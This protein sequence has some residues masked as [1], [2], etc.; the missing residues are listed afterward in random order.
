MENQNISNSI[1]NR[2]SIANE[3]KQTL[4]S[5]ETN[6]KN[7][8][9]KRGIYIYGSPGCGKTH[10]VTTLLKE[11]NYDIIKYDAG[12]VRNKALIDTITSNNISNRN[13]L[14]MM[15]KKVKKIA[16]VMDEI[17]GMNNGDKGGIT[18]LIKIIRQKKTKKQQLESITTN[19]IICIGNY[20]IDKKIKE[21][22]KVCNTY[23]LKSPNQQQMKTILKLSIPTI[24][25]EKG[26]SYESMILNYIQGDMRKLMFVKDIFN[27]NSKNDLLTDTKIKTIFCNKSYNED[28]KKITQSLLNQPTKLSQHNRFM[29]ETDRTIVALLWHENIVDVISNK[30]KS[31]SLPF[32]FKILK[33]MC[34]ADYIDRITF[35]SQIWQFNE[36][37]SLM[38]T[39]YNNKLYHD[40]FPENINTYKPTEVRFTKVLTKYSTEYNNILFIYNLCQKL[41]TD[42]QDLLAIFQE[43]RLRNT[44]E[45]DYFNEIEKMFENYNITKLDIRRMY[46]YLDKNIKKDVVIDLDDDFYEE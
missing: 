3:I 35:Q 4:S 34:Y 18:A 30:E 13:V 12:D 43:I 7:I 24:V 38:K 20:Y 44:S 5:F 29:N 16:I 28:S 11:M 27:K 21:L 45:S 19:P 26:N 46:R 31:K 17:D 40:T 22:M 33:N 23:E 2:E 37:S 8:S 15:T 36:M 9:F 32:Y 14:D 25:K 1:L 41:D 6:Y 10:F 39:F 42:K